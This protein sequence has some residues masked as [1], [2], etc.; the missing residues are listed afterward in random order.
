MGITEGVFEGL[1]VSG[2]MLGLDEGAWVVTMM[3]SD[4]RGPV[5]GIREGGLDGCIEGIALGGSVWQE[6]ITS[7][8]DHS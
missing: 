2:E 4:M 5:D 7:Y 1:D 8:L 3:G 6:V